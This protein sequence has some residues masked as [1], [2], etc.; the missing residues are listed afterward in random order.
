M[1]DSDMVTLIYGGVLFAVSSGFTVFFLRARVYSSAV[2]CLV[3][4]AA[5][6]LMV[7]SVISR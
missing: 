3:V 2:M 4:A 1:S 5:M 6:A 7:A